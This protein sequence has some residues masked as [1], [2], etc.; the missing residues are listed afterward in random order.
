MKPDKLFVIALVALLLW[1]AAA[2]AIAQAEKE[3]EEGSSSDTVEEN[4]NYYFGQGKNPFSRKAG[5]E[6]EDEIFYFGESVEEDFVEV[7]WSRYQD[8]SGKAAQDM[9]KVIGVSLITTAVTS[10]AWA[11]FLHKESRRPYYADKIYEGTGNSVL[12]QERTVNI[13]SLFAGV[14]LVSGGIW[15]MRRD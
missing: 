1:G 12:V 4:V 9:K 2:P 7:K 10:M 14:C 15:L 5:D 13:P 3:G 11:L 6:D 8:I